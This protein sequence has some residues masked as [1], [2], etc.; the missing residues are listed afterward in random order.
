MVAESGRI[1]AGANVENASFPVGHCAERSAV[2]A[3]VSAGERRLVGLVVATGTEVPVTLCG[4]C[5]QTVREFARDL[6]IVLSYDGRQGRA[7][8]TLATLLPSSFGPEDLL[9]A[10]R[11]EPGSAS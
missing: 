5:R 10:A 1:Y 9:A 2:A 11:S 7:T 8:T 4:L 3:A 6:P